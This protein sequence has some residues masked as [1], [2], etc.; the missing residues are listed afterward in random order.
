MEPEPK[1]RP[2]RGLRRLRRWLTI[3]V[4]I[5]ATVLLIT[6]IAVQVTS[7]RMLEAHLDGRGMAP[8]DAIIVLGAGID[9][10]GE[11]GYST[12]RRVASA[13]EAWKAGRGKALIMTGGYGTWHPDRSGALMMADLAVAYGVPREAI[14]LEERSTTT[15]ENLRFAFAI[16]DDAGLDRLA[17]SSDA[18]HLARAGALADWLGRPDLPLAAASG[19]ARE[20]F[21]VR[22]TGTLREALAWWLNLGKVTAWE[23]LSLLGYDETTLGEMIR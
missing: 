3:L 17:I 9:G 10:D 14:L 12:R 16:A 15:L 8:V 13:A 1:R 20:S 11:L 5:G 2:A 18:L 21:P 6:V 7:N 22:A 23:G 4:A 19:F